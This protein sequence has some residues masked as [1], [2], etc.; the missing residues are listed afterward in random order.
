[1]KK[2]E[3][4]ILVLKIAGF[5]NIKIET[6]RIENRT[7]YSGSADKIIDGQKDYVDFEGCN[8]EVALGE[9]LGILY[10]TERIDFASNAA[11]LYEL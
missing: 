5:E 11:I 2:K 4:L 3:I 9:L 10:D 6:E 8:F 1:M 7:H